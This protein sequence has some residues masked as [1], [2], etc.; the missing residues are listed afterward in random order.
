VQWQADGHQ[1]AVVPGAAVQRKGT[2]C[3]PYDA[4]VMT[5]NGWQVTK[6]TAC[7]RPDGVWV[8]TT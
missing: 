3:R 5:P 4:Q 7:R 8:Q 2:Y 1:Y 6:G